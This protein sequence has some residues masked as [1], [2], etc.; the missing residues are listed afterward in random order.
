MKC[1]VEV[2]VHVSVEEHVDIAI[3]TMCV[4][5]IAICRDALR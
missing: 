2:L 5:E 3:F 1:E 4:R